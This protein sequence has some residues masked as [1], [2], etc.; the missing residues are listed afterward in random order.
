MSRD[1]APHAG[2]SEAAERLGAAVR[3][4]LNLIHRS[5][6]SKPCATR[7]YVRSGPFTGYVDDWHLK[8]MRWCT[9]P[10]LAAHRA[11]APGWVCKVLF[12]TTR[13][14]LLLIHRRA[15]ARRL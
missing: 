3:R 2:A 10:G 14:V 1:R 7:T 9:V 6:C 12:A 13:P 11:G 15:S 5:N 8:A 4:R